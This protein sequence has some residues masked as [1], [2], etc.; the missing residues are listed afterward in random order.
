LAQN[1]QLV[2]RGCNV[3]LDPL[4]IMGFFKGRFYGQELFLVEIGRGVQSAEKAY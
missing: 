1:N 2:N 4:L 3:F